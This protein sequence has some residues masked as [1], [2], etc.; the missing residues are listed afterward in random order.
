LI[1]FLLIFLLIGDWIVAGG[2]ARQLLQD[3]LAGA[4]RNAAAGVPFFL[5]TG[6]NLATQAASEPALA[7]A[8]GPQLP[9]L[10]AGQIR[11]VPYFSEFLVLDR[12]GAVIGNFPASQ[13]GAPALFP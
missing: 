5:E 13:R 11:A 8:T 10:L 2:A 7:T 12:D 1:I 9:D 3:R 6:Q 4:G